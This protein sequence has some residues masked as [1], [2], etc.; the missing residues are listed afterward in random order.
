MEINVIEQFQNLMQ[1]FGIQALHVKEDSW[2]ESNYDKGLRRQLYAD[3]D[4]DGSLRDRINDV[5]DSTLYM[6]KDTFEE[7]YVT[8]KIPSTFVTSPGK[9]FLHIG[10]YLIELSD[11][12]ISKVIEENNLPL[13]QMRELREYYYSI[14]LISSTNILD[15]VIITQAGY[16][17][18]GRENV[19][20]QRI[21]YT[22]VR[23]DAAGLLKSD[24]EEKIS[25]PLIEE[26][27]SYED[28]MLAAI[29]EGD[30]EKALACSRE[31]GNFK[32]APRNANVLRDSKNFAIVL[33]T[34]CRKAV[35]RAAVHPA[36]IDAE[37]ESFARRIEACNSQ[38]DVNAINAE[39][40]RKYCLI[41][42][43]HSLKGYSKI[44]QDTLNF[45]DFNLREPL[46][47]KLISE[48]EMVNASY[49]SAQ[50]KKETGK[51]LTE[52]INQKRISSSLVLLT[53]TDLPVQRIAEQV[54][55]YDENYF[56]RLFRK[57]QGSTPMQYRN[58][59]KSKI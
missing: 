14:P 37:S 56:S 33:N 23:N 3:F 19:R 13:Y 27:Y 44:I 38:E 35:Q 26:R 45:I 42:R 8:L 47:L 12:L 5:Q 21:N 6:S 10:P 28:D 36:H 1:A 34:L 55:I 17:F 57:I 16:L 59:M 49:L 58:M 20:I 2:E 4:Y 52:Y 43:N 29:E 48:K 46:S 53:A 25:I 39:M 24:A 18:G 31:L 11:K 9:E 40:F 51:T 54:G 7:H 50:F 41:V 22:S 30:L 32:M 15:N